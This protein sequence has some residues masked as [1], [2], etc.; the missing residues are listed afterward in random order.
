MKEAF[1]ISLDQYIYYGGYPGAAALIGED[2][3]WSLYIRD[4]IVESTINKD[5]LYDT[6]IGKPALLK[7]TFELG[8]SY[9]GKILSLTKMVG[10][11]QDAGNPTT[12]AGYLN[13]LAE[14]GLLTGLQKYAVD[15]SR[16]KASI[17]KFQVYNNALRTVFN[18]HSFSEA[19]KNPGI[20]GFFVESAIGAYLVSSSFKD[21]YEVY[22][23][24]EGNYEVDYIIKKN[25]K[26]VAIE[27]KSGSS[28]N[29]TGLSR[30]RDSFNPHSAFIVGSG[31]IDIEEFLG[32]EIKRLFE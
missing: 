26:V 3:R 14:S 16:R 27:V 29:T 32:S 20:W 30:F 2:E 24:R 23:W 1:G 4:S 5:I 11:L 8:A 21:G 15:M 6:P 9:S 22:Y 7:Q 13:L 25:E 10:S 31:G 19:I 17:P 12:L 18:G 28:T